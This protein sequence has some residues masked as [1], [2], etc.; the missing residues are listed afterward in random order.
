[1]HYKLLGK[2]GLRVSELC[3]GTMTFGTEFQWGSNKQASRTVFDAFVNAGGNFFDTANYYTRG[4]SESYLGEWIQ[5][6]RDYFV[7]A[8]KYSLTTDPKNPNAQG[9]HKKNMVQALE[10]SLK[11]LKTDY[12]DLYW[13]HAWDFT[14][15]IEEVIRGLD[16]LIR[17]GKIL[18]IGISDA[19]AWVIS[20]GNAFAE[21]RGWSQFIAMQLEYSLAER[22][23]EREHVP[24]AD[25]LNLAILPWSP[26]AMGLF[27]GKYTG[28]SSEKESRFKINRSFSDNY[29]TEKRLRIAKA[30]ERTADEMGVAPSQEAVP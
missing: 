10:A 17:A 14:T 15:P 29:L 13:I 1:M 21:L 5:S 28:R 18:H 24:M 4:T 11:R 30:V 12:I 19:P 8:T 25:E 6:N 27:T 2:S 20:R 16:E 22:G 9:N 26:L 7:I 3:L 23:I